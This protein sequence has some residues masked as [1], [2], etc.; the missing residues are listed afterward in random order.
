V[1]GFTRTIWFLVVGAAALLAATAWLGWPVYERYEAERLLGA[2]RLAAAEEILHRLTLRNPTDA[3]APYLYAQVLRR[4]NRPAQARLMLDRAVHNGWP[5]EDA[6]RDYALVGAAES[7]ATAEKALVEQLEQRPRDV[8]VARALAEGYGAAGRWADAVRIYTIWL[9]AE[10]MRPDVLMAR[11]KARQEMKQFHKSIEDFREAARRL[12]DSFD[13]HLLLAQSLLTDAHVEETVEELEL[14]RKLQPHRP[15]PLIGLAI[16]SMERRS[17]DQ[18]EKL[19][20]QALALDERSA[21]AWQELGN[22]HLLRNDC[23]AATRAFERVLQI[24]PADKQAHLKL[25][26]VFRRQGDVA[27]AEAHARQFEELER[28]ER[29]ST[30]V[31]RK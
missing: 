29:E 31:P 4:Q 9:E 18:A 19:L 3:R 15:E 25:A 14:C 16:S 1:T 17:Y 26:Q 23:A 8:E 7:F 13:A 10:P 5:P 20:Q 11:G 30:S 2:G 6:R 24:D 27:Q 22:L 28:K 21:I 12:P